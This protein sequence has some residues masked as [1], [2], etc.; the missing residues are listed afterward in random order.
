MRIS[1]CLDIIT[2]SCFLSF[3]LC[4]ITRVI[5]VC[6]MVIMIIVVQLIIILLLTMFSSITLVE[7]IKGENQKQNCQR[8]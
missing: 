4:T 8:L 6:W 3:N 7:D 5:I 1:S 2:N